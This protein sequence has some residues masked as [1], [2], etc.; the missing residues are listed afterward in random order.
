MRR[1]LLAALLLAV[2]TPASAQTVAIQGATVWVRPGQ[3]IEGATVVVRN[4]VITD[5]GAGVAAPAGATVIDGKG[6]I[7]TAGL[8]DASSRVGLSEI[9]LEEPTNEGR[10]AGGGD[11]DVHAAYRVTDGYNS[12]S[13]T[14]PIARTGGLTAVVATP[15]GGFVSGTSAWVELSDGV[16][17]VVARAPLAMY[18]AL[19][20]AGLVAGKGSRGL[21][22]ERLRELLDDAAIYARRK[23]DYDRNQARRFAAARLDLEALV[24]VVQGRLPLVARVE[25]A[26]DI[27]AVLELAG[28]LRLRLV[29]E[30]GGEAWMLA[31]E[32]AAAR[33]PVILDPQENL[34]DDFDRIHVRDDAARLL[35][36]AGVTVVISTLGDADNARDLRQLAGN[37]IGNG[38][39]RDAALAAVTTAPA[40][41]FGLPGRGELRRGAPGDVVVWSGDPFELSS[42]PLHVLIGGVE[43]SLRTRQT[44]L[45]DRYRTLPGK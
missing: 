43:Q 16:K 19:G 17:P 14:I 7:V 28:A 42:R 41:A 2:A 40:Q 44:R 18:V 36:E 38:M 8:V 24:P 21:A 37:A 45:F 1:A 12:T 25:K 20:E 30:G 9:G 3:V 26:A 10:F 13:V 31:R 23:G 5:V 34:P 6:T 15:R 11:D 33:V 22:L 27:R 32:L 29:I 39:S 35:A 4:G